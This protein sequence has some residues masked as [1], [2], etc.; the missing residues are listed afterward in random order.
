MRLTTLTAIGLLFTFAA[1]ISPLVSPAHA[2][3]VA[4]K[5]TYRSLDHGPNNNNHLSLA[6]RKAIWK[7]FTKQSDA[8][9]LRTRH[10]IPPQPNIT[11][12]NQ[13]TYGKLLDSWTKH[14]DA[15]D[16]KHQAEVTR[17]I[18]KQFHLTDPQMKMLAMEASKANW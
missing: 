17:R 16:A 3:R 4:Y 13:A 9:Y 8:A 1:P 10:E 7:A 14:R 15:L 18:K 2:Q 12:Q 6:Q 5:S 11:R